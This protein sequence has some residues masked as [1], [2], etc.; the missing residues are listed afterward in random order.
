MKKLFLIVFALTSISINAQYFQHLY[1]T[2]DEERG[3]SGVNVFL[4]PQ[5]H[6]MASN[7]INNFA[8]TSNLIVTYTDINGTI[9]GAPNFNNEYIITSPI[10]GNVVSVT[11]AN[12]FELENGSG[13]GVVGLYTDNALPQPGIFYLQLDPM[14]NA[15]TIYDYTPAPGIIAWYNLLNV[16]AVAKSPGTD[17]IYITGGTESSAAANFIY[18]LKINSVTGNIIW[19]SFYDIVQPNSPKKEFA[20]DIIESPYMPFGQPEVVIVGGAYDINSTSIDGFLIRIN[21]NT[22]IPSFGWAIY[23][24]TAATSEQ[25]TSIDIANSPSGGSNG[26]IIGGTAAGNDFWLTKVDP[27]GGTIWSYVYDNSVLPGNNDICNDVKERLNT[28][29][30]YEYYACGTT[31]N[32]SGSSDILVIKTDDLG[33][34]ILNG[35]FTYNSGGVDEGFALDQYNG[36]GADG[37]SIFGISFNGGIGQADEYLIKAYFDGK[38]GCNQSFSTP[39]AQLGPG[40]YNETT[41]DYF[42]NFLQNSLTSTQSSVSDFNLCYRIRIPGG[43]NARVA[44]TEPKG[45]KEAKVSPNPIAQGTQYANVEVDIEQPTTAQVSVYDM[46]GRTYYAQTFTLVKGKN[47]LVLDMSNINMAQGMYTVKI[48]GENLNKNIMLLVK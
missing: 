16:A 6:L 7:N 24:G 38:S 19:S 46:L 13:F 4:Q 34:G 23:Y 36:T 48:Q 1:G 18:A 35:E 15:L 43:S 29:G 31:S 45:D 3:I 44:P 41:L 47:N 39:M 25:F 30:N 20:N 14:G 22:G 11:S 40:L 5:G 10:S 17:D 9:L 8:G 2:V 42:D 27:T 32:I 12:V 21:S 28:L 33:N 37:L 26:F